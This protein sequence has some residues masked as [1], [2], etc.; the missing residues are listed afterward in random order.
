MTCRCSSTREHEE[1]AEYA[2][3]I[4]VQSESDASE[5]RIK[6]LEKK[7]DQATIKASDAE[8]LDSLV[9]GRFLVLKV[10]YPSC[11]ACAYEG[12][13]V[14]VYEGVTERDALRWRRIDPHFRGDKP[15][16]PQDA[17]SPVARFPGTDLGWKMALN[18]FTSR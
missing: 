17:P 3:R 14:M 6:D 12:V 8:V 1:R 15:K 18:L 10:R 2:S 4:H 16:T 13:K 7:L 9:V 11:T 5:K